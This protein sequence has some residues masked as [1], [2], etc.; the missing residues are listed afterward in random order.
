MS[1]FTS[2]VDPHVVEP[3]NPDG[4]PFP[5]H[6]RAIA[7]ALFVDTWTPT[8]Y[9]ACH[10]SPAAV[11]PAEAVPPPDPLRATETVTSRGRVAISPRGW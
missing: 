5:A 1:L 3:R 2:P 9:P 4:G 6:P 8:T 7:S 10:T 11:G